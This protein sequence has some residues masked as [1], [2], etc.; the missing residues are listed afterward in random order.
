VLRAGKIDGAVLGS[1]AFCLRYFA[2]DGDD[3]L[4]VV[5]LGR[6]LHLSPA[7]EPLLAPPENCL[8]NIVFSTEHPAYGG[9]GTAPLESEEDGWRLPGHAAVLLR[10]Q[11]QPHARAAIPGNGGLAQRDTEGERHA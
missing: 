1:E 4:L 9:C 5:N 3:R 7:P 8:W 6:D 10:G 2:A 11:P